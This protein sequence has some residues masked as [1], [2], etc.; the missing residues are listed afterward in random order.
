MWPMVRK[1]ALLL[2][3]LMMVSCG[4]S[5]T[6]P[7]AKLEGTVTLNGQPL[8]AATIVFESP[9]QRAAN[10][11]VVNGKIVEVTTFDPNDGIPLGRH[12]VAIQASGAVG[13]AVASD[14]SQDSSS[15]A[16]YMG[17]SA[18]PFPPRYSNPETSG[19]TAEILKGT[20]KVEFALTNP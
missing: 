16:G 6:V 19:L 1:A 14:P 11:K 17:V 5:A 9:G 12:K 3:P 4:G 10:G 2:L 7:L 15:Q 8:E 18:P 20:N 13:A